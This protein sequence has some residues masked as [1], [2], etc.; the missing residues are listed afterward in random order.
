MVIS[1]VKYSEGERVSETHA[2]V[3]AIDVDYVRGRVEFITAETHTRSSERLDNKNVKV[4]I[5]GKIIS[6]E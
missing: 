1:I 3:I 5:N 6:E 2:S 4:Y